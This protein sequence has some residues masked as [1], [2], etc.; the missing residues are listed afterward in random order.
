MNQT[1]QM[2]E[3]LQ[4]AFDLGQRYWQQAD[5]E[6]ESEHKKADST[7]AKYKE[8]VEDT[9]QALAAKPS[10]LMRLTEDQIYQIQRECSFEF[11]QRK[12]A[13]A[14]MDAMERI[15]GAHS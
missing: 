10:K 3:A 13:H 5:S 4:R 2:R 9:V 7:H 12:F 6:Y 15:N 8:L 11:T 1:E 14:I